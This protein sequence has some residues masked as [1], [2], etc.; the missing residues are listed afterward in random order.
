M[1]TEELTEEQL[2]L[3]SARLNEQQQAYQ[4][5]T[6]KSLETSRD[7]IKAVYPNL[8]DEIVSK[9]LE[10]CNS[11]EQQVILELSS[12]DFIADIEQ[13]LTRPEPPPVVAVAQRTRSASKYRNSAKMSIDEG[14]SKIKDG[15]VDPSFDGWSAAR[16]KAYQAIDTTP[17]TYHYR[18]NAPGEE[19]KKGVWDEEE[20]K[21]FMEVLRRRGAD[22]QW[23]LFSMSIPGRVGYQCSNYYR[24]LLE[25]K[26]ITDP[27]YYLDERGKARYLFKSATE[28]GQVTGSARKHSKTHV[29]VSLNRRSSRGKRTLNDNEE[30]SDEEKVDLDD[31]EYKS[32]TRRRI[33]LDLNPLPGLIDPIT[34][35]EVIK[36]AMSPT[37]HVMSYDTW[38][39]CLHYPADGPKNV[40]PLTKQRLTKRQ[41]IILTIDNIEQYRHRIINL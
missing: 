19:Q 7:N 37:G 34:L 41:L 28:D 12:A 24:H 35:Q 16:I 36:P 1:F 23:G 15:T 20:K 18:F 10:Y 31:E 38:I 22:G 25:S 39:R 27:N 6:A 33:L 21:L 32:S 3:I 40:C 29:H 30:N 13:S 17:N 9:A 4:H 26:E 2:K 8:S 11:D 14:L 5:Y